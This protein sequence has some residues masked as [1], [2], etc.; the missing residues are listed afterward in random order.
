M[1][2][3]SV[4]NITSLISQIKQVDDHIQVAEKTLAR[5]ECRLGQ[6]TVSVSIGG[7]CFD[8]TVCTRESGYQ[9]VP[10][11]EFDELRTAC[12]HAQR[13]HLAR[14]QGRATGLRLQLSDEARQV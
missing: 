14:L 6:E 10:A 2:Q 4:N 3:T 13:R 8:L 11:K 12:I 5:L 1:N 7:V 9:A